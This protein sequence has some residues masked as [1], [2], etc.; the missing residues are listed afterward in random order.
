M[1]PPRPKTVVETAT[2]ATIPNAA[3]TGADYDT[4]AARYYGEHGAA[5]SSTM[6]EIAIQDGT[7]VGCPTLVINWSTTEGQ[8]RISVIFVPPSGSENQQF[9]IEVLKASGNKKLRIYYEW[10]T[11][12]FNGSF[13]LTIMRH[14]QMETRQGDRECEAAALRDLANRFR[15]YNKARNEKP[16]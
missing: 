4:E 15:A 1:P 10:P 8:A 13:L 3:A 9:K 16:G 11:V 2:A 5:A 12:V 7:C 14:F 6:W